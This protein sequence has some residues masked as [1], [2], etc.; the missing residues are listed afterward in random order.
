M[1]TYEVAAHF[2]VSPKTVRRWADS[3]KLSHIKTLGGHTR[4]HADDVRKKTEDGY[5]G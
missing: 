1:T 4:F 5:N 3:G 2:S